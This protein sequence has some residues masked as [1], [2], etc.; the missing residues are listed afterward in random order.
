MNQQEKFPINP[1]P[2]KEDS[3]DFKAE[4]KSWQEFY[5]LVKEND[6]EDL[7]E[8]EKV[9]QLEAEIS[10]LAKTNKA[11]A[12]SH[13][14]K[15]DIVPDY[16]D[17]AKFGDVAR[18]AAWHTL[19]KF[20]NSSDLKYENLNADNVKE[21]NQKFLELT[22]ALWDEVAIHGTGLEGEVMKRADQDAYACLK[23]LELAGIKTDKPNF[24]RQ[25]TKPESG[26]VMDTST[27]QH[28]V[29]AEEE[30]K[31]LVIDHH[32]KESERDSSAAKF[33]YETLLDMGLLKQE[34]YL[35]N[36]V[37]FVTK[38]DNMN[39]APDEM[40]KVLDNYPK[41]LYGLYF[42][43]DVNDVLELFK[44]GVDPIAI[45]PDEYLKSHNYVKPTGGQPETLAQ[46][47]EHVARQAEMGRRSFEKMKK[48]GFYFDTGNDRFG[49]VL[50]DTKKKVEKNKYR[51]RLDGEN[52]SNQL[53]AFV[54]GAGGYL[55]WS[56]E[57]NSFTLFTQK[58][59]DRD[60]FPQGFNMRGQMW[61]KLRGE[62]EKLTMTLEDIFS[63]LSG[64]KVRIEGKLKDL[65][66]IDKTGKEMLGLLDEGNLT[67]ASLRQAAKKLNLPLR[68][69]LINML[70]QRSKIDS[71]FIKALD[72]VPADQRQKFDNDALAIKTFLDYQEEKKKAA[73]AKAAQ[74][75]KKD[76]STDN[77]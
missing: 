10:A 42:R 13:D 45:L 11:S 15:K 28:G 56:P 61:I 50:I 16:Q 62:K 76:D 57:E 27:E 37:A 70:N 51:N 71:N 22:R 39:F 30:G 74:E 54:G 73:A 67:E 69:I 17:E 6:F 9:K 21:A 75:N 12:A 64:R 34:K 33:V 77:D 41:N 23:L 38:C 8:N 24:V 63:K 66:D 72:K 29:I 59:M 40:E 2:S 55:I 25:G 3:F 7:I 43:M 19:Y 35:D 48:S 31:R 52:N 44:K 68:I 65:L 14:L 36:F 1:S 49:T 5:D 58:K 32:G 18:A 47:S 60:M 20:Y 26:V 53:E 46:L 4:Q